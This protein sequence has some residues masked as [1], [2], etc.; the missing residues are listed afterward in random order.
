[1]KIFSGG[2]SPYP[3]YSYSYMQYQPGPVSGSG[4]CK[5]ISQQDYPA[6]EPDPRGGEHRIRQVAEIA[7]EICWNFSE[8]GEEIRPATETY[9]L[10]K[11][12]RFHY[13]GRG[14]FR[15]RTHAGDGYV[16]YDALTNTCAESEYA[17]QAWHA[18]PEI[19]PTPTPEAPPTPI[20]T[21]TAAAPAEA[22][23]TIPPTAAP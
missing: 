6:P 7:E 13:S 3:H 20:P 19:L 15:N 10:V 23:P 12:P 9:A 17:Q 2:G 21:A 1:M 4:V 22:A 5:G 16:L 18:W 11:F 14:I 8:V